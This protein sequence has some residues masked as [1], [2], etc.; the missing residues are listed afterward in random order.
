MS[1]QN[2]Y[3]LIGIAVVLV[4]LVMVSK[5]STTNRST[6]TNVS[7]TGGILYGIGNLVSGLG[8]AYKSTFGN[9]S[10]S[11]GDYVPPITYGSDSSI[12][13]EVN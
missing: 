5:S 3:I 7:G 6:S 2:W 10:D 1:K 9:K 13:G 11:G 12:G 4:V 8:S